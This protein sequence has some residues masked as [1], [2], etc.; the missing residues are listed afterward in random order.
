MFVLLHNNSFSQNQANLVIAIDRPA[1][2]KSGVRRDE[3]LFFYDFLDRN[4]EE[5][6]S[7]T[8]L[9]EGMKI[10]KAEQDKKE[11]DRYHV[12]KQK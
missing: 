3:I 5:G 4:E 9:T 10:K 6:I 11:F 8:I 2:N 1:N 7:M 12:Q